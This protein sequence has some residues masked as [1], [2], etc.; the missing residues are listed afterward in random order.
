MSDYEL[1]YDKESTLF[2][3]GLMFGE[4]SRN[5]SEDDPQYPLYTRDIRHESKLANSEFE[6]IK[7]VYD[8]FTYTFKAELVYVDKT[9][10]STLNPQGTF[11]TKYSVS[12]NLTS[13]FMFQFLNY[14][15]EMEEQDYNNVLVIERNNEIPLYPILK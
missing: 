3:Y 10:V 11:T 4:S 5:Y 14:V 2:P 15:C 12:P 13:K 7:F 8:S 9:S 6:I 1:T